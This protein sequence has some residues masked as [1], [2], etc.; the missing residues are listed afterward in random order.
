M[1]GRL[2]EIPDVLFQ[3]R[4]HPGASNIVHKSRSEWLAFMDTSTR[5]SGGFSLPPSFRIGVECARSAARLRLG[6]VESL[7]CQ[8]T[9]PTAWY[10]RKC[11]QL[12]SL[13]KDRLKHL[14][15]NAL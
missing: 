3:R 4:V 2:V 11:Y 5:G 6:P 1:L 10:Y 12:G 9:V 13:Y 7:A 14:V 15:G 8:V